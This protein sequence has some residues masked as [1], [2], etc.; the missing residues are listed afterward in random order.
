M[1]TLDNLEEIKIYNLSRS[2]QKERESLFKPLTIKEINS[3]MR[4]PPNKEKRTKWIHWRIL[5][6]FKELIPILLKL[7]ST[8]KEA[9][10]MRPALP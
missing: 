2:K 1:Q 10:S 9:H 5:P 3:V 6:N 7:F 4:N 8:I